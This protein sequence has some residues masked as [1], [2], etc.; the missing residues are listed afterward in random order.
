MIEGEHAYRRQAGA[1]C[2]RLHGAPSV[3]P[4]PGSPEHIGE[5][6]EDATWSHR[7]GRTGQQMVEVSLVLSHIRKG[8]HVSSLRAGVGFRQTPS[9]AS[10]LMLAVLRQALLSPTP[11][12]PTA[13]PHQP[14]CSLSVHSGPSEWELPCN[15]RHETPDK[16]QGRT[17]HQKVRPH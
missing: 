5:E 7:P 1:S 3:D 4:R 14:R 17:I 13:G 10:W 9:V 12:V 6:G 11:Q 16:L 15:S 8:C 2:L